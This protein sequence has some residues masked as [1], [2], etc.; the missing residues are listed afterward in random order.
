M[1]VPI[2]KRLGR[3]QEK[4]EGQSAL[5]FETFARKEKWWYGVGGCDSTTS[6]GG[7]GCDGGSSSGSVI[8]GD[9]FCDSNKKSGLVL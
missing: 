3:A 2:T 6:S 7:G 1:W 5:C 9:S 4:M 8:G